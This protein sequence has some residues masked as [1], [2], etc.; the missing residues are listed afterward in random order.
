MLPLIVSP[1]PPLP[2]KQYRATVI[3]TNGVPAQ[4]VSTNE[5][6]A[7][8]SDE[9]AEEEEL[10]SA[11]EGPPDDSGAHETTAD[12]LAIFITLA[13]TVAGISVEAFVLDGPSLF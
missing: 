12:A 1:N 9:S 2:L 10:A 11:M 8:E 7:D 5:D 13:T 4:A 3:L 6:P